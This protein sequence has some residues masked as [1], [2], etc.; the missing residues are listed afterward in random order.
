MKRFFVML[1]VA[2]MM[3]S[4]VP[5]RGETAPDKTVEPKTLEELYE[6][7]TDKVENTISPLVSEYESIIAD[8]DTYEKYLDNTDRIEAYYDKPEANGGRI[9]ILVCNAD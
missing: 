3:T 9:R 8:V 6:V 2:V 7:V 4:V 5:C 1:L